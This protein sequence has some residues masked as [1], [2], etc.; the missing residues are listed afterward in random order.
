MF[1]SLVLMGSSLALGCGGKASEGAAASSGGSADSSGGGNHVAGGGPSA[2][3]AGS[4]FAGALSTSAGGTLGMGD[5]PGYAGATMGGATTTSGNPDCPPAQWTCIS[6]S[7]CSYDTGWLPGACKC[8]P[9]RPLKSSDCKPGQVFVCDSTGSPAT[10]FQ[11]ACVA[12]GSGCDACSAVVSPPGS[13]V[14]CDDQ[15]QPGTVLCGC[16]VVLLK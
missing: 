2:G 11:C 12:S 4:G 10:G 16:A 9:S 13:Y 1:R 5:V 14:E 6:P 3:G 8:D 7:E 15:T